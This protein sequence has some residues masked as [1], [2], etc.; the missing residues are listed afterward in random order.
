MDFDKFNQAAKKNAKENE[1]FLTKLKHRKKGLDEHFHQL[2]DAVFEN[3]DCLQCAN[4]CKTTSPVF[5]S[6]DIERIAK[7]LK[8]TPGA[9]IDKY[10]RIDDE[11]DY[12][13]QQSP[14][15]FLDSENYCTIYEVRPK[16][17]REYP[18][19]NRKN[20]AGILKLTYRNTLVCPAVLEIVE[21]LKKESL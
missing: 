5:T 9:F 17:C 4:C 15:T 11:Q 16:A 21:R 10:L 3:T 8:L 2:H 7:Q 20:M 13:L 6:K 19:T 12:V 18:H 14:C 1:K